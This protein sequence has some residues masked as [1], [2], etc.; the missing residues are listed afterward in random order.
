MA[1]PKFPDLIG[2]KGPPGFIAALK[3]AADDECTTVSE[4]VRRACFEKLNSS[5]RK[6]KARAANDD[7]EASALLRS[8]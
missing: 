5:P 8:A 2:I 3:L 4:W 6:R 7:V 1:K